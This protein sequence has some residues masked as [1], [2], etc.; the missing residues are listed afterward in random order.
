LM[1]EM[2]RDAEVHTAMYTQLL[3]GLAD[4]DPAASSATLLTLIDQVKSLDIPMVVADANGIPAFVENLPFRADVH[5]PAGQLRIMRYMEELARMNEPMVQP[6]T[7]TVYVGDPPFVRQMRYVP[8][9]QVGFL[10]CLLIAAAIIVRHS[11]RVERERI[12][13]TMA[14]ESAHQMATPLSSL[15]G[16]IE[17]LRL[18]PEERE[19]LATLPSVTS[20]MEA[21]LERLE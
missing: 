17:I 9:L 3:R 7:G 4:P 11:R 18:P 5:D 6:G 1:R 8:Y 21:D 10:T 2:R 16:W 19:A 13:A 20:E 15:T 14:R 12:W